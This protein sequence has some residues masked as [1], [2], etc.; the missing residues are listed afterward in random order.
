VNIQEMPHNNRIHS[1]S[2]KRRSFLALLFAAGDAYVRRRIM[3]GILLLVITSVLSIPILEAPIRADET[4][5]LVAAYMLDYTEKPEFGISIYQC[6][7]SWRLEL[8]KFGGRTASG[9]ARWSVLDSIELFDVALDE[10][11][12]SQ[13]C[14]SGNSPDEAIVVIAQQTDELEFSRIRAAWRADQQH[15]RWI[16]LDPTSIDCWNEA[17]GFS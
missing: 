6:S 16:S 14:S 4:C 10:V 7:N 17:A 11:V 1:D 8:A 15:A 9:E 13:T 3:K 5:N 12:V 2:K